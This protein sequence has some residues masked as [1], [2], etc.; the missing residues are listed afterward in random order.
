MLF[1]GTSARFVPTG[2][3]IFARRD[4]LWAV[5]FDP[6]RLEVAGQAQPIVEHV[7]VNSGGLALFTVSADGTLAYVPGAV[8]TRRSLVWVD[9]QGREEPINAP[10]RAYNSLRLSPEGTR[11]ALEVREQDNDIWIWD[12]ARPTL[13][14]F[15]FDT[16]IDGFPV[17][18]PDGRRIAFG[19]DRAGS[20]N[21]FWQSADGTGA[22]ER[23]LESA[24]AQ[25]P[26]AFS[27]DGTRLVFEEA[28]TKTGS[29]LGLLALEGQ[30]RAEPLV[31]TTF[32]E[33]HADISPDGSWLAYQSDESGQ[34][35]IYVRPFRAADGGRR[36][37]SSG[38]GNQ[39][40][41]ARSGREL[42]YLAL[43]GRLMNVSV[44]T[45]PGFAASEGTTVLAARYYIAGRGSRSYDVSPDGQ[46]FFMIKEGGPPGQTSGQIIVVRPWF[47]EL[48]RRVPIK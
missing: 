3:I 17:W 32:N 6:D 2:H 43:D 26:L 11:A 18:T 46:R 45:S 20:I 29:D 28:A 21:M 25:V 23:L 37:I 13:T 5:P 48:K 31:Q 30:R 14:R 9:R 7:Q 34:A 39:P 1:D 42:F 36:Q 4:S 19:S 41:W 15:T 16:A 27:P 12:F 24:K 40:L 35:E 44:K 10:L 38:G 33:V 22:A 47:E 8:G